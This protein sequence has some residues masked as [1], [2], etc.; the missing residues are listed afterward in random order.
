MATMAEQGQCDASMRPAASEG[1]ADADMHECDSVCGE[2]VD[3]LKRKWQD[4]MSL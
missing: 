2:G 3:P 1:N 4:D